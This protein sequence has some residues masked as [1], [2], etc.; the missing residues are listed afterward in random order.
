[1]SLKVALI[2]PTPTSLYSRLLAEMIYR[3]DGLDLTGIAVRSMW[4]LKRIRGELRRDGARLVSK[5]Y[6]KLWLGEEAYPPDERDT[7]PGLARE[8]GLPNENL[9]QMASRFRVAHV[10]NP[11]LNAP[12]VVDF[13]NRLKPDVVAFS[14]GGLLRE[15][16]LEIP[17]LGVLN[18]HSGIL[19]RYRGMDVVEWAILE[20]KDEPEIGLTLHFMDRGVD[21]GPILLR[22]HEQ[23]Q[24][25]DT[26]ARIRR[27]LEP[28]MVKLMLE[29]LCGL[30]DEKSAGTATSQ[31][32]WAAILRHAPQTA[33]FCSGASSSISLC[34]I[35]EKYALATI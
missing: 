5:V 23:I 10:Q 20:K 29:G 6:K 25:G 35:A 1:M 26:L 32:R 19:P 24:A 21:T 22:H 16:I 9:S 34:R 14:G 11:D 8:V 13:L 4:S 18:C 17:A 30:R 27:R 31:R 7:L 28:Q 3:E 12:P 33:G 2:A 15:A